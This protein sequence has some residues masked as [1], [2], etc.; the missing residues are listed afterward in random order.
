MNSTFHVNIM[1]QNKYSQ[2]P[3]KRT[4][5]EQIIPISGGILARRPVW[6]SYIYVPVSEGSG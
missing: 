1:F 4:P 2:V 5:N 3:D 6:L